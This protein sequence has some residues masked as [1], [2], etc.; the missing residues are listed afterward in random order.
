MPPFS[1]E[2]TLAN[3]TADFTNSATATG[4]PPVGPDVT[5]TDTAA[6]D[7]IAPAITIEKTPDSQ[8]FQTGGTATF[9]IT[10]TNTG[11]VTLTD[12]TVADALAPGCARTSAQ[13][14]ANA[15]L[16][17]GASFSYECTLANVTADFTNSATATGTPPAGPDVTDTD[18]AGVTVTQPPPP[19]PPTIDLQIEKTDSPNPVNV[20]GTL[21]YTLTARN[22]GP[23]TATKVVITDSLPATVTYLSSSSTQGTCSGSGQ[24]VTCAIGTMPVGGT[25]TVTI[26]VRPLQPGTILN[27]TVIV[28]AEAETNTAN[29]RD[30]E[31]TQVRS[32]PAGAGGGG[33]PDADRL[34]EDAEG[35]QAEHHQGRRDP[36]RQARPRRA[37]PRARCGHP[38]ERRLGQAGGGEDLGEAREGGHRPAPDHGSA[39]LVRDQEDRC[40]RRPQ[41]AARHRLARSQSS[42]SRSSPSREEREPR[43]TATRSA[44]ANSPVVSPRRAAR[45][46]AGVHE[47]PGRLRS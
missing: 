27:V 5:D 6:V 16:A 7:V 31:P 47:R 38:Q 41:A 18:T 46:A 29:N 13:L 11:D 28:G 37:R 9:T 25:V 14:G 43:W 20:G 22:N 35:R 10:V 34:D 17:P 3:V 30:E 36:P 19:P 21:T 44:D 40:R 1:Y 24:L 39:R 26:R 12:V 33:V 42:C 4:T 2:C 23:S 15:T 45:V 32:A 8:T